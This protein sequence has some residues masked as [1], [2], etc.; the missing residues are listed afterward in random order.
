MNTHQQ[1]GRHGIFF[2]ASK[3]FFILQL[4]VVLAFYVMFVAGGYKTFSLWS[5]VSSLAQ[6]TPMQTINHPHAI[7]YM[8]TWPVFAL[9]DTL[10]LE[11]NYMFGFFV[12]FNMLMAAIL[13]AKTQAKISAHIDGSAANWLIVYL[14]IFLAISLPMNGRLSYMLL[15]AALML[16]TYSRWIQAILHDRAF[17]Y[18]LLYFLL[19]IIALALLSISSGCFTVALL[20]VFFHCFIFLLLPVSR[21]RRLFHLTLNTIALGLFLAL[22]LVFIQKNLSFYGGSIFA[23]LLH[24]PGMVLATINPNKYVLAMAVSSAVFVGM[25]VMLGSIAYIRNHITTITAFSFVLFSL[26][27][28]VTGYSAMLTGLIAAL[29]LTVHIIGGSVIVHGIRLQD[30]IQK[31]RASARQYSP[32]RTAYLKIA[33]TGALASFLALAVILPSS[34]EAARLEVL[35]QAVE[36]NVHLFDGKT[37]T[38]PLAGNLDPREMEADSKGNLYIVDSSTRILRLTTDRKLDVFAGSLETGTEGDTRA[39]VRFKHISD[40]AFD[41]NDNLYV[42]DNIAHV[43][44]KITPAGAVTIVAGNGNIGMPYTNCGATE[45]SFNAPAYI[46]L[47][48]NGDLLISDTGFMSIL[49]VRNGKVTPYLSAP[50]NGFYFRDPRTIK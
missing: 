48:S 22:Q 21:R 36:D 5:Q 27:V 45:C 18:G 4:I 3:G 2:G 35:D 39:S 24:G 38:Y 49:R 40:I 29:M 47:L 16:F 50:E 12:F 13:T 25:L 31:V 43:V 8:I 30:C 42:A 34:W 41:H 6:Y 20:V 1:D 9:A 11:R 23:M 14:P 28:G 32:I 44:K 19:T 46:H 10:H 33:L 37:Y 7:R 15:G 17:K 26:A